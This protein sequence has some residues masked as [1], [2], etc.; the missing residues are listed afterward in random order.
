MS[1]GFALTI[2]GPLEGS[3][4]LRND[5]VAKQAGLD[6]SNSQWI[7]NRPCPFLL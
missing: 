5:S 2:A 1:F 4:C 3:P 7:A 6:D